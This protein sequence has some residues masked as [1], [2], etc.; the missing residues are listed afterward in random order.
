MTQIP[1]DAYLSEKLLGFTRE[2]ELCDAQ[3]CVVARVQP[4]APASDSEWEYPFPTKEELDR[5]SKSSEKRYTTA[6][7]LDYLENR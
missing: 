6:E 5:L 2:L 7:M 1:I 3:G 4:V